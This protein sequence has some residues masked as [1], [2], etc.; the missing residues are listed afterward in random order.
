MVII[1]LVNNGHKMMNLANHSTDS[2]AV[3][4]LNHLVDLAKTQC[5]KRALLVDGIAN[6]ALDLLNLNC[7]HNYCLLIIR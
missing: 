4:L 1:V 5:L 7:S 6:L 3:F 2:R